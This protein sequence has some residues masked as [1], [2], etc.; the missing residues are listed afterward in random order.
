VN[1]NQ[2][3]KVDNKLLLA[4]LKPGNKLRKEIKGTEP[5]QTGI[6]RISV[7]DSIE[8]D[9]YASYLE[10]TGDFEFIEYNGYYEP[11]LSPNDTYVSDQWYLNTINI[12]NTWNITT[13]SSSVKYPPQAGRR[14]S[15]SS[16]SPSARRN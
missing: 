11:Y 8:L 1:G 14:A 16:R 13:G 6:I 9:N 5:S 4:K 7:P 2:T 12:Y 15:I 3:Y 10:Q